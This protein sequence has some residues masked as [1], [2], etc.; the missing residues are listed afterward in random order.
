M[1]QVMYRY[2]SRTTFFNHQDFVLR[3]NGSSIPSTFAPMTRE[4]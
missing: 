1:L 4:A 3:I 2:G